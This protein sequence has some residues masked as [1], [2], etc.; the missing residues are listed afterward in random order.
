[1]LRAYELVPEAYRQKF[2]R[3]KK[4]ES[5]IYAEFSREKEM[6]FD[7]WCSAQ[8]VK[9]LEDLKGLVLMEEF[10]NCLPER[11]ATYLSEQKAVKLSDAAILA[12]DFV[13][14][15]KSVF[16]ETSVPVNI[17]DNWL[18]E[19]S[20]VYGMPFKSG[21]SSS[22]EGRLIVDQSTRESPVCFYCKKRGHIVAYCYALHE[23]KRP[24][25][26]VALIRTDSPVCEVTPVSGQ[27]ELKVF[28]PFL[29][30]GVVS[31]TE[32]SDKISI[33]ILR[34]TA[35]SQSFFFE[36]HVAFFS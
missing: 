20:S 2:C 4:L 24:V 34:D 21:G 14:T 25:K 27:S 16:C 18:M 1:M 31:L 15:H 11:V 5:H 19:D 8:G 35:A 7:K 23:D 10:N 9:T 36:Q 30:D 6:L 28:A 26:T 13:L 22:A 12:D 29:M 32:E 3:L 17:N 33:T